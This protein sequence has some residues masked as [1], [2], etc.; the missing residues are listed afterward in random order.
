MPVEAAADSRDMYAVHRVF[1]RE[2]TNLPEL[3]E[4]VA[5]GDTRRAAVVA[6]HLEFLVTFLH[7]HHQGEDELVWPRLLTRGTPEISPL[8]HTMESQHHALEGTLKQLAAAAGQWRTTATA[9]SRDA[10]VG[11]ARYLLTVL[12]EHLQLE[13]DQVLRLIDTYL[14][15]A[16]WNQASEHTMKALKP[17]KLPVAFGMALYEADQETRDIMRS[18]IP[19]IPWF[20]F[21]ALGPGAY[22]RYAK[23]V[24]GTAT[25]KPYGPR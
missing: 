18:T 10:V 13:E 11:C 6:D 17:G 3:I 7:H 23:R 15:A 1:R 14:T 20:V 4:A 25:P 12:F 16:E 9:A 19:A 5:D 2:F 24:Y 22:K 21:S 8:V